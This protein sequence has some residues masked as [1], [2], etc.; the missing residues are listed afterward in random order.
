[1][2]K[3]NALTTKLDGNLFAIDGDDSYW[4]TVA[5]KFFIDLV[6]SEC[7]AFNLK[8]IDPLLDYDMLADAVLSYSI[9]STETTVIIVNN[10]NFKEKEK[11]S[12]TLRKILDSASDKIVV[13]SNLASI[14]TKNKGL[15]SVIDA[16][17]LTVAELSK[18]ISAFF[19]KQG[20]NPD[21]IKTIIDYTDRDMARISTELKK[22]ADYCPERK[23]TID[24]VRLLVADSAERQIY[25]LTNAFSCG[26][27]S[28]AMFLLNRFISLG[29]STLMILGGL[30]AQYRRMLHS[31]LSALPDAALAKAL[32]VKDYAI[33][34]ARE[35]SNRYTDM[36]LRSC[37]D[38]VTNA[39]FNI[40]SGIMS[41][42]IAFSCAISTLLVI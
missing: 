15:F 2:I 16:N 11:D 30:A 41:E 35:T 31:R 25:I 12:L 1:M 32:G 6:P 9:F 20:I 13:F 14:S 33:V 34:K 10:A 23:V 7:R 27:K 4:R 22:L 39:E 17:R 21:A 26:N 37:L 36:Q 18:I 8:I 40:K 29:T 38:A 28:E 19:S 42:K 5:I 3:A 24:D